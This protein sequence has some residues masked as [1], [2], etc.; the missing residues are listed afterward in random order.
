MSKFRKATQKA[1]KV[2]RELVSEYMTTSVSKEQLDEIAANVEIVIDEMIDPESYIPAPWG[3][4]LEK[5]SDAFVH[6]LIHQL[7]KQ[8][9]KNE[10]K[11]LGK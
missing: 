9:V 1:R 8:I 6:I 10:F 3:E 7:V 2:I 4:I 5:I 11:A